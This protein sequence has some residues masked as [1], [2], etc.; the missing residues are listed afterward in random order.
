[1]VFTPLKQEIEFGPRKVVISD[2]GLVF[3]AGEPYQAFS[4][5]LLC[6]QK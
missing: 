5:K 6:L 3:K 1:M 4:K 2:G